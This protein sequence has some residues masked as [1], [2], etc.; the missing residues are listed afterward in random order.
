MVDAFDDFLDE[1]PATHM[2]GSKQIDLISISQGLVPYIDEAFI[3]DP[4]TGE[5]NHS[6]LG[7]DLDFGQLISRMDITDINPGHQ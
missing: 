6:Y 7:I 2:N 4:K 3:L 5:G 1:H